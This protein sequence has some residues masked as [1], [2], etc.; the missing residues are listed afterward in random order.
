MAKCLTAGQ[1]RQG[2]LPAEDHECSG[3]GAERASASKGVKGTVPV[4]PISMSCLFLSICVYPSASWG[5]R[6]GRPSPCSIPQCGFS[7]SSS[8]A[9]ITLAA[10]VLLCIWLC[11]ADCGRAGARKHQCVPPNAGQGQSNGQWRSC[12]AG[13]YRHASSC[14]PLSLCALFAIPLYLCLCLC[15][16]VCRA[17]NSR[18][19]ASDVSSHFLFESVVFPLLLD[20][21]GCPFLFQL[22]VLGA[23]IV[24]FFCP[25][26][27]PYC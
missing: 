4:R 14:L 16:S 27:I 6:C 19:L 18:P 3:N 1:R 7:C 8:A 23:V 5:S 2:A 26:K 10:H 12:G 21:L 25:A 15:I 9:C 11:V 13:L 24:Y 22:H 17:T 20:S